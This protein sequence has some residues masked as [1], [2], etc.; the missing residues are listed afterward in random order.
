[1][2]GQ[3]LVD[4][5]PH[6]RGVCLCVAEVDDQGRI[7]NY[8]NVVYTPEFARAAARAILAE[9]DLVDA[10]GGSTDELKAMFVNQSPRFGRQ[11]NS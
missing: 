3:F 10:A 9:A 2:S 11:L 5:D 8:L 4:T 1:M 6:Y 7:V